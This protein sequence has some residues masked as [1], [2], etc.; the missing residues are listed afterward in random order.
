MFLFTHGKQDLWGMI[1]SVC[2]LRM[3]PS[4]YITCIVLSSE[5]NRTAAKKN[6]RGGRIAPRERTFKVASAAW[7]LSDVCVLL[8]TR[9]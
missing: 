5:K 8:L 2:V 9:V 1:E 3:H 4:P 6:G 7:I